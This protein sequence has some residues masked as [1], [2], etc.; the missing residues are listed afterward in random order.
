ML[1]AQCTSELSALEQKHAAQ[2]LKVKSATPREK[3]R[4]GAYPP[5]SDLKHRLIWTEHLW[6]LARPVRCQTYIYL[7]TCRTSLTCN[8]YQIIWLGEKR[9]MCVNN[10]PNLTAQGLEIELATS[11]SRKTNTLTITPRGQATVQINITWTSHTQHNMLTYQCC[12]SLK[13]FQC[14]H[15]SSWTSVLHPCSTL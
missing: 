2:T 5:Y 12:Y 9:H 15:V 7:P 10:L 14:I 1:P 6:A 13:P 11:L 4:W 3:C 8:W